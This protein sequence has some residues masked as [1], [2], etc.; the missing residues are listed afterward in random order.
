MTDFNP[1]VTIVSTASINAETFFERYAGLVRQLEAHNIRVVLACGHESY[2]AESAI[3]TMVDE[4]SV[5]KSTGLIVA[6]PAGPMA[7]RGAIRDL[8]MVT[9]DKKALYDNNDVAIVNNP[10]FNVWLKR[11][12][13][14]A[15]LLPSDLQPFTV[16]ADKSTVME[17]INAVSSDRIIIKP[18]T[19]HASRGII[20]GTKAEIARGLQ[21]VA[22]KDGKYL[23]SEMVDTSVGVPEMEIEG[24]H[25]VRALIIGTDVVYACARLAR[26]SSP[27]I[28]DDPKYHRFYDASV[29]PTGMQQVLA[30][31]QKALSL[32]P[33]AAE[34]TYAIDL[35]RGKNARGE[36]IDYVCEINRRP[37]RISSLDL[38]NGTSEDA[39]G[40]TW[41]A[42]AWDKAEANLLVRLANQFV[43][44]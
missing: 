17:A 41:A 6:R 28:L 23:V 42:R 38:R 16:V 24:V 8:T 2:N 18:V 12:D 36:V 10:G 21:D 32:L 37:Y 27:D 1:G 31:T 33:G 14:I 22:L 15:N 26:A 39:I 19:G 34:A 5:S 30:R 20:F 7:A 35:M 25:N 43:A 9:D 4:L 3:F 13:V 40:L 29:L 11:K 44:N